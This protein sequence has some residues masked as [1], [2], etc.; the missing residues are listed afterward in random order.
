MMDIITV[1]TES[2]AAGKTLLISTQW[3]CDNRSHGVI[4]KNSTILLKLPVLLA[5]WKRAYTVIA[6]CLEIK[7]YLTDMTKV[8]ILQTIGNVILLQL[9]QYWLKWINKTAL[10]VIKPDSSL[11]VYIYLFNRE[12][13]IPYH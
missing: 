12:N 1:N 11:K 7:G 5:L 13:W 6:Y 8:Y 10:C 4:F 9:M 3:Q 2:L